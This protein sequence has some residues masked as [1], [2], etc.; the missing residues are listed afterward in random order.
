MVVILRKW[1]CKFDP[2]EGYKLI[3]AANDPDLK[4]TES[5]FIM[6]DG[7]VQPAEN[8]TLLLMKRKYY[9]R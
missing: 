9:T 1:I 3:Q 7:S 8:T 4:G 2:E 5:A 6:R